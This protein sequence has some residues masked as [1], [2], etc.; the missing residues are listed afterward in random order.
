MNA[1]LGEASGEARDG[2]VELL[3]GDQPHTLCLTLGA[4]MEIEQGLG[5]DGLNEIGDR[6]AKPR[7]K[8]LLAIVGALLRGGGHELSDADVA[9]L[10]IDLPALADKLI[11]TFAAAGFSDTARPHKKA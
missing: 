10:P 5:I 11:E 8:D 9:R 3:I 4:L 7:A 6:L 1:R 2:R